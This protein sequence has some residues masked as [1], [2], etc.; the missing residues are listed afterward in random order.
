AVTVSGFQPL[1]RVLSLHYTT[2]YWHYID[3]RDVVILSP[4]LG[5][6]LGDA[7][8]LTFRYWLTT[9]AVG[10][11]DTTGSSVDYV[12]SAGVRVGWRPDA[13]LSLGLDYTYGVQLDRNP[14]AADLLE[15]RSHIVTLLARKLL[16]RS[17]GVDL[18]LSFE[19]RSSLATAPTVLGEVIEGGVFARW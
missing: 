11:T 10:A 1:G 14:S 16:D 6:A 2:A 9:V 17:F 3:D 4:A 7:V 12:H 8:D 13:R 19:R 18:A 15:L 5:V